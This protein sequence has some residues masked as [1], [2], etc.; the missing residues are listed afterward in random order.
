MS[1]LRIG[2]SGWAYK[3][4]SGPFYPP[5]VKE[6]ARLEYY[7]TRFDTAEINASFYR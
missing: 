6:R 2:C 7:A 5:E 4:W 3:D 1:S